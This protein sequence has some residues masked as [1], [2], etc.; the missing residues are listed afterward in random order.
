MLIRL[1]LKKF[2]IGAC[3]GLIDA[4]FFIMKKYKKILFL[5]LVYLFIF[6]SCKKEEN[7]QNEESYKRNQKIEESILNSTID[8]TGVVANFDTEMAKFSSSFEYVCFLQKFS[9]LNEPEKASLI[10]KLKFKTLRQYNIDLMSV[11]DNFETKEEVIA[12][13]Q[14]NNKHIKFIN[15][16]NDESEVSLIGEPITILKNL[17]NKDRVIKVGDEYWKYFGKYV[18]KSKNLNELQ[19]LNS[20]NAISNSKL[21]HSVT[22]EHI[23]STKFAN[24]NDI[25]IAIREQEEYNP[26]WCKNDRRIKIEY[27]LEK[28]KNTFNDPAF[29]TTTQNTVY[30]E[31]AVWALKKGIPCIWYQYP[32]EMSW[33]NFHFEYDKVH[34]FGNGTT[35]V[36]HHLWQFPDESKPDQWDWVRN[37]NIDFYVEEFG[38]AVHADWTKRKSSITH[39]GMNGKWYHEDKFMYP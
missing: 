38:E 26:A 1:G 16:D 6:S 32:A 30:R 33:H 31:A 21:N 18:V 13:T 11:L 5:S 17:L 22:W 2:L 24:R 23:T 4:I 36:Q 37:D 20:E 9:K 27:K 7:I 15:F 35:D 14:A 10:S 19:E 29:G 34:Y 25:G 28:F 39:N 3:Y 8:M 12:Y